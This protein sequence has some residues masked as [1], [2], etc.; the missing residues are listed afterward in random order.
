MFGL[1]HGGG[2]RGAGR[3]GLHAAGTGVRLVR[4]R[5]GGGRRVLGLSEREVLDDE[6]LDAEDC[7][8]PRIMS[9]S[10]L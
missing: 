9:F 7:E 6:I 2:G 4:G 5:G 8:E 1:G 10:S 3:I